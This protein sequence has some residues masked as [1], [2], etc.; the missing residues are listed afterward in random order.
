VCRGSA[1]ATGAVGCV[2]IAATD[3]ARPTPTGAVE[4]PNA[5]RFESID[6][7]NQ[8]NNDLLKQGWPTGGVAFG[9]L[10]L[11]GDVRRA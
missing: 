2:P 6:S 8:P 9:D 4:L 5:V 1:L 10:D 11:D 3:A 7:N